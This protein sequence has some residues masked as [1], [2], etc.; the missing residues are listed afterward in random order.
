MRAICVAPEVS[1]SSILSK[2]EYMGSFWQWMR[3]FHWRAVQNGD[4]ERQQL[5][6]LWERS[7]ELSY[8]R[9]D[10][11][12]AILD[13][14]GA[15]ARRLKEPYWD[16]FFDHWKIEV[17]LYEKHQPAAALKLAARAAFE[18]R[19]PIY[20]AFAYRPQITLSLTAC[21]LKLDPIG[22]E[23]QLR[24]AFEY[25]R[26]QCQ[27]DEELKPYFA[28]QWSRFLE[29]AG[30]PD[31][32]EAN[33]QHLHAAYQS[34]TE[35]YVLFALVH[36]CSTLASYDLE[37]ARAHIGEFAQLGME[38]CRL[39]ERDREATIFTMW[40]AVAAR[41]AGDE[42]EAQK[43]YQRA[44]EMQN[45]LTS[46]HNAIQF[47]AAIYHES[48]REWDEALRVVEDEIEVLRAHD[49]EFLQAKRRLKQVELLR[50]LN[51]DADEAIED[52]RA[53]ASRL[54][55]RAHWE[56]QLQKL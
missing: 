38:L 46:P 39:E 5:A 26:E 42:T 33:W 10:Q 40:L 47:A 45:R 27:H 56:A 30:A 8:E 48:A 12:L 52:L 34:G 2:I 7:V 14:A 35:H 25:A 29:A 21:Y 41:W 49:L 43:L 16:L 4:F 23:K 1:R 51:R 50:Q 32:V 22:Y 55:S 31:A 15:L 36:L 24:E 37:A 6:T 28:Q 13:Q 18:V 19:K 54:K 17:L 20:D 11:K 3:D 9:P 53:L 44:H